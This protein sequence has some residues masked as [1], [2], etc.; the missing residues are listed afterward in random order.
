MLNLH[1]FQSLFTNA[2]YHVGSSMTGCCLCC[3]VIL[4]EDIFARSYNV[5]DVGTFTSPVGD[6]ERWCALAR[7]KEKTLHSC[8]PTRL[9][10]SSPTVGAGPNAVDA[11]LA[12]GAFD[13]IGG[14]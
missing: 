3:Q 11:D 14:L 1:W 2:R 5:V 7:M 6:D 10:V 12:Q 9:G 8:I 4:K 13:K